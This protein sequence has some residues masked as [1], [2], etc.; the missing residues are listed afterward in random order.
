MSDRGMLDLNNCSHG[1]AGRNRPLNINE[2][3]KCYIPLPKEDADLSQIVEIV[4]A[5][6]KIQSMNKVKFNHLEELR[7]KTITDVALGVVDVRN[8]LIPDY[9][10]EEIVDDEADEDED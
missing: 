10:V 3:I 1:A 4:K 6:M 8:V 9:V 2:L 5:I 7:R